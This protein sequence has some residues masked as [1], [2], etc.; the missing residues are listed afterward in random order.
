MTTIGGMLGG[1]V[2]NRIMH[3][4]LKN[5]DIKNVLCLVLCLVGLKML[6]DIVAV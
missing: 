2:G 6:Y 1:F 4:K 3:A 5:A